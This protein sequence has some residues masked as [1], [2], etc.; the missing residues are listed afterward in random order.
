M[1]AT[2]TPDSS[3]SVRVQELPFVVFLLF[4]FVFLGWPTITL[5]VRNR[6]A[7][8]SKL[9]PELHCHDFFATFLT[10]SLPGREALLAATPVL[11][12]PEVRFGRA[13]AT[14]VR[15]PFVTVD[16]PLLVVVSPT[17]PIV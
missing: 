3:L 4:D 10:L 12:P 17:L 15:L 6:S 16:A 7:A 14:L 9:I 11:L 8:K 13:L 5:W 2:Q 1:L